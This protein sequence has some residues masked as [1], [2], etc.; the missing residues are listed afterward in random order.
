M[1]NVDVD[2]LFYL[3]Y[4]FFFSHSVLDMLPFVYKW[5]GSIQVLGC[6]ITLEL[7]QQT[8]LLC[9]DQSRLLGI[10]S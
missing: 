2:H 7:L 9:P 6:C 3:V 5:P 8:L 1:F 4:K 10:G